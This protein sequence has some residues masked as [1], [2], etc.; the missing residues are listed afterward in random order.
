MKL[1][2]FAMI[3]KDKITE[4]F[5]IADDFYKIFDAQIAKYTLKAESKHKYH[6]ESCMSKAEM[7]LINPLAEL[8]IRA[9]VPLTHCFH[10]VAVSLSTCSSVTVRLLTVR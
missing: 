7:I 4:I 3:I 9:V 6:S 10:S 8:Y 1:K 5:R 2:N